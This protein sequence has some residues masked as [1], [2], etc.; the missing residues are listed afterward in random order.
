MAWGGKRRVGEW[1]ATSSLINAR[2]GEKWK[3][4][5]SENENNEK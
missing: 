1:K 2:F 5:G 3:P 4:F